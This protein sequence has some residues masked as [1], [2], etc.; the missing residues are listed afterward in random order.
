MT[1][2]GLSEDGSSLYQNP[3]LTVGRNQRPALVY[4]RAAS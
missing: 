4:A 2:T 1:G 3:R